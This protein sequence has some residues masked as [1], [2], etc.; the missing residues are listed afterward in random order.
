MVDEYR[1]PGVIKEHLPACD[2]F[3]RL[4][5]IR[6]FLSDADEDNSFPLTMTLSIFGSDVFFA[7]TRLEMDQGDFILLSKGFHSC[8]VSGGH[9]GQNSRRRNII[10][11]MMQELHQLPGHLQVGNVAV[12]I[13]SV[14][15]LDVQGHMIL[16]NLVD[17]DFCH[18]WLLSSPAYVKSLFQASA[19]TQPADSAV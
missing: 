14:D 5:S 12:E 19:S 2:S 16:Q 3:I 7:N 17:V 1:L 11:A 4:E 8:F 18:R 15:A 13:D 10:A 9:L 6:F